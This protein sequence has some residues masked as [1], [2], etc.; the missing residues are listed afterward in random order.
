MWPPNHGDGE[1]THQT[2][3]GGEPRGRQFPGR[4]R[5]APATRAARQLGQRHPARCLRRGNPRPSAPRTTR[6]RPGAEE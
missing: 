6:G 2:R 5:G 4:R 3:Q 1:A